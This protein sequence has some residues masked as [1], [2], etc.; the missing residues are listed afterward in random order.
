MRNDCSSNLGERIGRGED[1]REVL[2]R[3]A[4]PLVLLVALL[5]SVSYAQD[6]ATL[7]P[8]DPAYEDLELLDR[9]GLV[10]RGL[11]SLRP[12][13]QGR[14]AWLVR[15]ARTG[16]E[17]AALEG[18]RRADIEA[19]LS[20]L[21]RRFG[22]VDTRPVAGLAEIELGGGRSPGR[23]A[24]S[25]G[26][27]ELDVVVNPLWAN[28]GGRAYGD[29]RSGAVAVRA[30]TSL[31]KGVA[32]GVAGRGVALQ[33]S[34]VTPARR[35]GTIEAAYL[36]ATV[37]RIALEV[38]R[39]AWWQ[40]PGGEDALLLSRDA[41]PVD[42]LRIVTDRPL[43]AFLLGDVEFA[44]T[45]ADLGPNQ[46][47]PGAKLFVMNVTARP[48]ASLRMGLTLVNKQ[49][50]EGAPDASTSD[51]LKDLSFFW[52]LFRVGR[53]YTFSE[54]LL[55][56]DARFVLPG[57]SGT[58]LFGEIAFTDLGTDRIRDVL[59][60]DTG[61]RLGVVLPRLG[62]SQR[63]SLELEGALTTALLYRH[64]QFTTGFAVDGFSQGSELGPDGRRLTARYRYDAAAAGWAVVGAAAV[65]T[66]SV[67][68]HEP[69]FNPVKDVFRAGS[70]PW[71]GRKRVR[72]N[73]TKWLD[74]FSGV[75]VGL[76]VER[77]KN[78]AFEGGANRNNVAVLVRVWRTF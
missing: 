39:D 51:R 54:K 52:D 73:V 7:P 17:G 45:V 20:R 58:A 56:F 36:R 25:N 77:V 62:P 75:D 37:G 41:P 12:L 71:E 42:L 24:P 5:P 72:L 8:L 18:L 76:G 61:Y 32:V 21:E 28:R 10:P 35:D 16:F 65:E 3:L 69:A 6:S 19:V 59:T 43:S 26:L 34:G 14:V 44:L 48:T 2:R 64:L 53:D 23:G 78:F 55:G 27:G 67:D 33:A 50:G 74:E 57:A 63:H 29:Q 70:L 22:D 40:Q 4:T 30:A 15:E 13:S 1:F 9:H 11:T 68:P 66:R 49:A 47:F 60:S 46:N 31:G 38:G